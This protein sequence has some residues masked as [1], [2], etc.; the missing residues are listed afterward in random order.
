[1]EKSDGIQQE[2]LTK[3]GAGLVRSDILVFAVFLF[4]SFIFWYLN[5]LGKAIQSDIKFPVKFINIPGDRELA[6]APARINLFLQGTGFS[7]LKLKISGKSDPAVID[8]LKVPYK[9]VRNNKST[10]YYLVTSG[11]VQNFNAQLKPECRITSVK[12]DTLFFSFKE[13]AGE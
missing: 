11:L 4:L 12:P 13:A 8:L 7:M 9:S 1:M 2:K 10:D 5:S 3:K 6:E